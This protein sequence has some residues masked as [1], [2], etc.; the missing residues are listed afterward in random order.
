MSS[1]VNYTSVRDMWSSLIG[2]DVVKNSMSVNAF[3][4]MRSILH[5]ND[6]TN[7]KP[8]DDPDRDR[9]FKIRPIVEHLNEKFSSVPMR[10]SLSVDEQI[11]ATKTHHYM[12]Q[13]NPRKPHKWG[14]K[15]YVLCDDKGFSHQFEIYSGQTQSRLASEPDL[16]ETGNIVVRLCRKVPRNVNYTIYCDNFYSSL[17]LFSYLR[18]QGIFALGTFRRDRIPNIPFTDKKEGRK[19][20]RGTSVEFTTNVNDTKLSMVSWRDN[21]SVMLGSTLCG[22]VPMESIKR[23]DRKAKKYIDVPCPQIVKVYNKHMGGVDLMD[24]H[25]GRHHI[26]LRSRKW[27]FRMFYHMVDMAVVNAWILH[28]TLSETKGMTQKEF[29]TD[30]G[31]TLCKIGSVN[32]PKRGRP[33]NDSPS[34]LKKRTLT[35]I[36]RPPKDVIR[37]KTNHWPIWD[38]KKN[39]CKAEGCKGFTFMMSHVVLSKKRKKKKK[40]KKDGKDVGADG[41]EM[42]QETLVATEE[43]PPEKRRE[44]RETTE[45]SS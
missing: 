17:L 10:P 24:S 30:L 41:S 4:S 33:S 28:S 8:L 5:F 18:T 27:Y 31:V 9:L 45:R 40:K 21:D 1:V 13:Y 36:S 7:M 26:R 3:E 14:Y 43:N 15:L 25:I 11:C 34:C 12:R 35:A 20:S 23:Y 38:E 44:E 6:N 39:R 29:R 22:V 32:T 16:G 2:N 42:R 37:D 19:E